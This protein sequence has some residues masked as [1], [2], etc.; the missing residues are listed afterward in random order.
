MHFDPTIWG[1]H[2]W[3]FL[4][5]V[6]ETYPDSPNEITKRKYYDLIQNMPLFIP[7]SEMG[8][9]FSHYL[10]KYPVTPYLDNRDSFIRWVVFIHNKFN[11]VIG[12]E[13][14]S[15]PMALDRYKNEYK[16]KPIFFSDRIKIRKQY[17]YVAIILILFILI[18]LYYE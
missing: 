10:D 4:H 1:P 6:A 12:K 17:V 2:Y 16:P 7:I 14:L 8:N 5:T 9:R 3:F 18:Y 15:L 11:N 13:E